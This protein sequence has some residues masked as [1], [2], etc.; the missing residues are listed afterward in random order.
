MTVRVPGELHD[1]LAAAAERV[2]I[3]VNALVNDALEAAVD[4]IE[5]RTA[6][7]ASERQ[8]RSA[9]ADVI[10]RLGGTSQ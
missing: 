10:E 9:Y 3:S 8:A 2:G 7:A 1:R 5:A 4:R 6:T